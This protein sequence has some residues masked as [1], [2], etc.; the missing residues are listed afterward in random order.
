MYLSDM[1]MY[2]ELFLFFFSI[3][4]KVQEFE[5]ANIAY[6]IFNLD[7]SWYQA[8][9]LASFVQYNSTVNSI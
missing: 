1:Y 8:N 9:E 2:V 3:L 6:I 5:T 7:E 4:M